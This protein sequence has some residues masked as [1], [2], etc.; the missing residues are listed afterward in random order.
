M[1][2]TLEKQTNLKKKEKE[3]KKVLQLQDMTVTQGHYKASVLIENIID[4]MV[5]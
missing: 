5:K 3:N 1:L 2:V 4:K